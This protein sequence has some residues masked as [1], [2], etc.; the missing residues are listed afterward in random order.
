MGFKPYAF[1]CFVTLP[2]AKSS[3]QLLLNCPSL[4]AL[5]DLCVYTYGPA[6]PIR[7]LSRSN[8]AYYAG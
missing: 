7:P 5:I 8:R 3:Q 2:I 4:C 1:A 6:E